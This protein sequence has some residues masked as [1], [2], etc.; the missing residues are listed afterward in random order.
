MK[1]KEETRYRIHSGIFFARALQDFDG[2]IQQSWFQQHEATCHTSNYS[3]SAV[4][5]IFC[6]KEVT[7]SGHLVNFTFEDSLKV[8]SLT[9]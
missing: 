9:A 1:I 5:E 4:N 3:L 8:K 6:E 2:F 7:L